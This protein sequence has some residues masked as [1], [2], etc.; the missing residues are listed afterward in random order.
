MT[1]ILLTNCK[2]KFGK[3]LIDKLTNKHN[4]IFV[5]AKNSIENNLNKI[6][7]ID[8][9]KFDPTYDKITLLDIIDQTNSIIDHANYKY[10]GIDICIDCSSHKHNINF[11][12][13]LMHQNVINN[14]I[15]LEKNCKILYKDNEILCRHINDSYSSFVKSFT[16]ENNIQLVLDIVNNEPNAGSKF[17]FDSYEGKYSP[18]LYF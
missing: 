8:Y 16:C 18:L 2:N 4:I 14:C 10:G 12:V 1:T 6:D 17:D 15:K 13:L 7:Y 9:N 5:G 3:T 11:P